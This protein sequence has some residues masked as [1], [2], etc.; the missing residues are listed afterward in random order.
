M[1]EQDI[2]DFL[3][4]HLVQI[5][6]TNCVGADSIKSECGKQF[7]S[8]QYIRPDQIPGNSAGQLVFRILARK[9]KYSFDVPDADGYRTIPFIPTAEGISVHIPDIQKALDA[10]ID[11]APCEYS[12][13]SRVEQCS[14]ALRCINPHPY[15]AANCKYRK[16]LKSGKVFYGRNRNIGGDSSD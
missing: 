5:L 8:V 15:I 9:N 4:P 1:T 12:C 10:A 14:D 11:S 16:I 3:H 7:T 6:V 2:Y 13:C